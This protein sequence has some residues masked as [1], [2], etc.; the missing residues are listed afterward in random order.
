MQTLYQRDLQPSVPVEELEESCDW[1]AQNCGYQ[2]SESD[3]EFIQ[4]RTNA[5]MVGVCQYR[6][7]IDGLL[8]GAAQHWTINR[9]AVIDRNIMRVAI[10][11]IVYDDEVP[12]A[13]AIDEALEI[14]KEYG[15][16]SSSRFITGVLDRINREH[17]AKDASS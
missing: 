14:S 11:E 5:L 1:A 4:E 9:M 2:L 6:S 10:F 15:D 7:D 8:T 12:V 3:R 13:V 17:H 16:D